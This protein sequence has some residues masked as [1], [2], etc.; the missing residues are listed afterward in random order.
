MQCLHSIAAKQIRSPLKPPRMQCFQSQVVEV[1]T[2]QDPVPW[3]RKNQF[4]TEDLRD[5]QNPIQTNRQFLFP[6]QNTTD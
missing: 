2:H 3:Y 4:Q 5:H 1:G 6:Q